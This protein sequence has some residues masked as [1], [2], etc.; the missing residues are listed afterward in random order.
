MR[1]F[2]DIDEQIE[3]NTKRLE[4]YYS[5]YQ[6]TQGK[7]SILV[8]IYSLLAV[9][10]LQVV[11]YPFVHFTDTSSIM[12]GIYII[13]LLCFFLF[14]GWS[15]KYTY[16][17]LK[18]IEV[19]YI[20][21]PSFFY[22]DIREQYETELNTNDEKILNEYVKSTYLNELELA[23]TS[24]SELFEIKSKYYDTAFKKVLLH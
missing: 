14:L 11:K 13:L 3:Q 21:Y 24:N 15:I 2:L 23:V 17:L 12:I 19:A 10:I 8:I 22:N 1:N 16:L 9:Y 20:N 6:K 18:P 4:F 7:I 5:N